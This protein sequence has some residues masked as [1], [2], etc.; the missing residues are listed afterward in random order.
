[1]PFRQKHDSGNRAVAM[2]ASFFVVL[3]GAAT[4]VVIVV[5]A[6][7]EHAEVALL[8]IAGATAAMLAL[9]WLLCGRPPENRMKTGWSWLSGKR[10]RR[11]PYRVRAKLPPAERVSSPPAPP[12]VESIRAITGRQGTWVPAPQLERREPSDTGS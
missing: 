6:G 4:C 12:T 7:K 8:S 11:V 10:K 2:L 9:L 3:G 5:S 1:M